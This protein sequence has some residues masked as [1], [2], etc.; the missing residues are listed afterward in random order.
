MIFK[1]VTRIIGRFLHAKAEQQ[2]LI[3]AMDKEESEKRERD[4]ERAE[5]KRAARIE[6]LPARDHFDLHGFSFPFLVTHTSKLH[7]TR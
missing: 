7:A 3:N 2:R 1:A 6:F 5:T 4:R